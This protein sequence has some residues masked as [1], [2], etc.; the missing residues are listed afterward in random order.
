LH[1]VPP[2]AFGAWRQRFAFDLLLAAT[3]LTLAWWLVPRWG[4]AG[5]SVA[6][7]I[8]F[9]TTSCGLSLFLQFRLRELR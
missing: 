9:A 6:Y 8:A 1:E 3:L 5:L 2:H 7:A 4:A